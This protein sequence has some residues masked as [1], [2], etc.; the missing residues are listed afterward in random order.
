MPK[1]PELKSTFALSL[2]DSSW[3]E[4]SCGDKLW[5]IPWMS[6]YRWCGVFPGWVV[7]CEVPL[8]QA[9]TQLCAVVLLWPWIGL[10]FSLGQATSHDAMTLNR[11]RGQPAGNGVVTLNWAGRQAAINDAGAPLTCGHS[12]CWYKPKRITAEHGGYK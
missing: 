7:R 3:C 8:G 5:M 2:V 9:A 4:L 1:L 6:G 12:L 11:T 10:V